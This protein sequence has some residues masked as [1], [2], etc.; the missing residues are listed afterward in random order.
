MWKIKQIFDGDYGCEETCS[1]TGQVKEPMVSVTL[2]E[3]NTGEN[4][5]EPI[6]YVTVPDR[7]L[8]EHGLEEGS[9][10]RL[11]DQKPPKE[12]AFWGWET[13]MSWRSAMIIRGSERPGICMM[14]FLKSGAAKRVH[15]VCAMAG[16]KK[17]KHWGSVPLQRFLRRTFSVEK[18]MEF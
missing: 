17:I 13:Q 11:A 18:F 8:T 14:P 16:R 4:G 2:V 5:K 6:K 3:E 7:F 12:Y 1:E 15:R 9:D 10:W